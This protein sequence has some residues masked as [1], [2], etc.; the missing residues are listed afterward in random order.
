VL[1]D[2]GRAQRAPA[3]PLTIAVVSRGSAA[4][5]R[6]EALAHELTA[7][8]ADPDG[9]AAAAYR[10]AGTPGGVL[11]DAEGRIARP[12][13]GGPDA[14]RQLLARGPADPVRLPV[15]PG[16]GGGAS[17]GPRQ[18]V[19]PVVRPGG[20]VP[21]LALVDL[22]GETRRLAE[23]FGRPTAILFWSPACGYCQRMLPDRRA[24][25]ARG[26]GQRP[27]LLVL[28]TGTAE[29]NRAQGL[30]API[31]LDDAFRAG[32]LLGATGTP[33][34]VLVD[35]AGRVASRVARGIDEVLALLRK[36]VAQPST[37]T[38]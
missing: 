34:A 35:P 37:A 38:A 1:P 33:N 27:Q 6:D 2:V 5:A 16:G 4:R 25:E 10:V 23:C 9:A 15:L 28:S 24:W 11:V 3:A 22:E 30:R 29:A 21:D 32:A 19:E 12:V 13:A 14:I 31:L 8:L 17:N 36:R 18:Q 7:V 20:A 26:G